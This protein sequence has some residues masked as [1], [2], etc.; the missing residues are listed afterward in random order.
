[1]VSFPHCKINLGL[2]VLR[3]RPDGYHDLETLFYPL[4]LK[5]VLEIIPSTPAQHAPSTR[6]G[7]PAPSRGPA[8]QPDP[9]T[10]GHPAQHD[11]TEFGPT[12]FNFTASG[13]PIPGDP[14]GNLCAKAWFLLKKDF[15]ALPAVDAWLYKNIPMGAGLGGGS[16]DGAFML[17]LLDSTF[18]LELGRERLAAYALQLGSDC[19]FF[20]H[21]Q[22]CIATG[23]GEILEPIDLDLSAWCIALVYPGI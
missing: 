18:R 1:M 13:L 14:A 7:P 19:P 17:R 22:P 3:K 12:Q 11:P 21:D 6:P 4:P 2:R 5:D 20:L 9:A 16:A 8:A 10:S 23:R 15:P